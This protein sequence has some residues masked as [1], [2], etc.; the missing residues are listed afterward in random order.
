MSSK[1]GFC[2]LDKNGDVLIHIKV[3]PNARQTYW[4]GLYGDSAIKL[5]V[6]AP[7]V[8][9]AANEEILRFLR[10]FLDVKR[11]SVSL[12]SGEKSR[13]KVIRVS[14]FSIEE[15]SSK[16]FPSQASD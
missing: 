1:S 9:G 14:G 4:D 13:D 7:P 12:V 10:E 5:K 16:I 15:L 3:V 11:H 8:D 2:R 6:H